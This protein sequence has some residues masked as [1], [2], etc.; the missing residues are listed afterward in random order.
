MLSLLLTGIKANPKGA[1]VCVPCAQRV[2]VSPF[3]RLCAWTKI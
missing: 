3:S 1:S 2:P